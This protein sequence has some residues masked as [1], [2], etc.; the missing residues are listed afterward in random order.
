MS[1]RNLL[2]VGPTKSGKSTLAKV[3]SGK[4]AFN[5]NEYTT[6]TTTGS[7]QEPV[8]VEWKMTREAGDIIYRVVDTSGIEN[9]DEKAFNKIRNFVPEGIS[10]ILFVVQGLES[11]DISMF[12]LFTKDFESDIFKYITIV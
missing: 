11:E 7:Y 9:Y 8:Y 6:T 10:Q 5:E 12:K 1:I 2:I 4:N 3:L